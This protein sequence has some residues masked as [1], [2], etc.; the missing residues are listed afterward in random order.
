M[1]DDKKDPVPETKPKVKSDLPTG[2]P[3]PRPGSAPRTPGT[4][5]VNTVRLM[6]VGAIGVLVVVILAIAL[7]GGG[8]DDSSDLPPISPDGTPVSYTGTELEAQAADLPHTAY[9]IGSRDGTDSYELTLTGEGLVYVRYL[10]DGAEAGDQRADFLTVGSYPLPDA[11]SALKTAAQTGD[12][13]LAQEDGYE[14]LTGGDGNNAYVVFADE[15]DIQVEVYS[16]TPGEADDLV[17]SG[18]V[19]PLG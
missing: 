16:A 7:L 9:W 2:K 3:R 5:N 10:T 6:I 19:E 11:S 4:A 17:S 1:A 12:Q 15:P 18:A 8:D 14:T 13:E